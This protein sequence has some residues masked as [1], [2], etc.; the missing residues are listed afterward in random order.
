M[1]PNGASL[2]TY[3]FFKPTYILLLLLLH[4]PAVSL[5]FTI[6]G[7]IFAYVAIFNATIE[8]V[9][10]CLHGWCMLGVFLLPVFTCLGHECK[11]Q[12]DRMHASTD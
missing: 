2:F 9:T 6:L 12:C 7:E 4:S 5:G 1:K 3:L 8:V 11:D 10:F